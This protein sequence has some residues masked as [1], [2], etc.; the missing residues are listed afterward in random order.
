MIPVTLSEQLTGVNKPLG[1]Q[2]KCEGAVERAQP[3]GTGYPKVSG[4]EV[5]SMN[6]QERPDQG[7]GTWWRLK[8][9]R[10]KGDVG[11]GLA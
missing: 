7:R 10:Q 8:H 6:K 5:C 2:H 11:L 9:V 1:T 3:P 4:A